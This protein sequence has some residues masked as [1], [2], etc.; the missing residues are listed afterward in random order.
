MADHQ[1]NISSTDDH[2]ADK[3]E[4]SR[5]SIL[6]I[7]DYQNWRE[8]FSELLSSEYEVMSFGSY[9]EVLLALLTQAHLFHAAI[10]DIRLDDRDRNNTQGLELIKELK[11]LANK[12]ELL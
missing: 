12:Q 1:M 5:D 10:V 3:P 8:L 4:V 7:D 2:A 11:K 9:N 6:I